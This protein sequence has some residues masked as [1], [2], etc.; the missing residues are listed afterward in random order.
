MLQH[1]RP[2]LALIVFGLGA[3]LA[4]AEALPP[5]LAALR[6][7]AENG[8]VIAEYNLGLAY[9]NGEGVP[10]DVAEA[11]VWLSLATEQGST[12]KGLAA[13]VA[14]M[15]PDQLVEGKRRLAS[16]RTNLG[17]TAKPAATPATAA[18]TAP[19]GP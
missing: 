11:Y 13:L 16:E 4:A 1:S 12:P 18:G 15:T 5:Q 19:A 17:I 9:A 14:G 6:D 3:S 2:A 7:K 8:N 10:V